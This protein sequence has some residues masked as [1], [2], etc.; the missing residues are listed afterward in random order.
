M[1]VYVAGA[2][3]GKSK[4]K[5]INKVQVI[6]NIMKARRVAKELWRHGYT[7][8]CPHCN[9]ILMDGI[10]DDEV[11]LKGD[12]EILQRCDAIYMMDDWWLSSGAKSEYKFAID[13]EIVRIQ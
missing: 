5:L 8:I 4:N 11:F 13:H 6:S 1:I 2:Y 12:L 3:R 10:V 9:S 7:V